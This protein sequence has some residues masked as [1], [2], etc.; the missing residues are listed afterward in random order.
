MATDCNYLFLSIRIFFFL[1]QLTENHTEASET[2]GNIFFWYS[3]CPPFALLHF[4][5]LPLF[6]GDLAFSFF[7][8]IHRGIFPPLQSSVTEVSSAYQLHIQT[9][10]HCSSAKVLFSVTFLL[11]ATHPFRH[12][13]LSCL[14]TV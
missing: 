13:A 5:Q 4:L 11:T 3:V 2:K 7:K 14:L 6:S 9:Q 8:G 10:F 1:K 12:I